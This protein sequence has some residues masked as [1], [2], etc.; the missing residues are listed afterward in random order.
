MA[1]AADERDRGERAARC[2]SVPRLEQPGRGHASPSTRHPTILV[3]QPGDAPGETQRLDLREQLPR[4]LRLHPCR[5]GQVDQQRAQQQH[6]TLHVQVPVRDQGR[7]IGPRG[8]LRP[9]SGARRPCGC[10]STAAS[11]TSWRADAEP[12]PPRRPTARGARRRARRAPRRSRLG[13]RAPARCASPGPRWPTQRRAPRARRRGDGR[14]AR[15]A[16]AWRA[17]TAAERH[18]SST[19]CEAR[20]RSSA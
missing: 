14:P 18:R 16:A 4:V 3:L 5:L 12:G 19:G 2:H 8:R 15:A 1:T 9:A 20:P 7:G 10:P 6:E 11:P 13:G 17:L